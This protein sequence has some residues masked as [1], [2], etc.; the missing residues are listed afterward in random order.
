MLPKYRKNGYLGG[1]PF[2]ASRSPL[3]TYL[4]CLAYVTALF[5]VVRLGFLGLTWSNLAEA[6]VN[7][8]LKALYIGFRFDARIA[9]IITF[10]I[11]LALTIP[12]FAR[13]LHKN[14]D[15]VTVAYFLIFLPIIAIYIADFGH[16]LYLGIRINA[17]VFDLLK[18]FH[19]A[20]LMLW[21]SYP[22]IWILLL[23]L[24]LSFIAAWFMGG[25]LFD[26]GYCANWCWTYCYSHCHLY[27]C[28]FR[29]NHSNFTIDLVCHHYDI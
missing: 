23:L 16:Y 25:S 9:A 20:V 14:I 5:F 7:D 6:S 29:F 13:N 18:D 2:P 26:F 15:L 10:P 8:I 19:V 11:G 3:K 12:V 17:Y 28:C 27:V 4:L 1:E 24:V 22:I 21:Q